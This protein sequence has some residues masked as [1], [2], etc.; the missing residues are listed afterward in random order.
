MLDFLD[1]AETLL[2]VDGGDTLASAAKTV[3]VLSPQELTKSKFAKAPGDTLP[4]KLYMPTW[5]LPELQVAMQLQQNKILG[6][7]PE[8]IFE[9]FQNWGGSAREC[10]RHQSDEMTAEKLAQAVTGLQL[11]KLLRARTTSL[12]P[13][14]VL[15]FTRLAAILSAKMQPPCMP[16]GCLMCLVLLDLIQTRIA[17]APSAETGMTAPRTCC[18]SS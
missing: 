10:L 5:D 8:G 15:S 4:T 12:L 17:S 1:D 3:V 18:A 11:S 6:L 16:C 13:K 14:E 7:T 2:I 9:A